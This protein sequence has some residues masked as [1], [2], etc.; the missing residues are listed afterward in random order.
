MAKKGRVYVGTSGFHYN[1]WTGRFYPENLKKSD[2][3]HYYI[4]HFNTLELN[5]SFYNLPKPESFDKWRKSVPEG[6][7]FSVKGS[8]FI[9]HQ[10]KLKDSSE[11]LDR[12]LDNCSWLHE[13]LGPVLFQL[14]PGWKYNEERLE[15]FL[16]LLPHDIRF[17]FE[18]RNPSWYNDR[19]FEMLRNKNSAFCIYELEYH[20]SPEEITADFIY[21]RL[22][23]PATKYA[24]SYSD[25]ALEGWADKI[26]NW[27]EKCKDVY[28]YFD[29]D[30]NAYA[31]FNAITL[32]KNLA[33]VS[34]AG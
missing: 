25:A 7:I 16:N 26:L 19:V 33:V 17:T 21:I 5:S 12:L 4:K 9:T 34:K 20:Q 32:K 14:P 29:N 30:Q 13:K 22:H 24:G 28:I 15:E 8:R 10:K 31:A 1:H 27:M 3:L 23:G 11:A 18:F 6:F 2:W